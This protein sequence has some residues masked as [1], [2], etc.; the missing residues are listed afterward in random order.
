[1]NNAGR[2]IGKTA[3][4]F[5]EEDISTIMAANFQYAFHLS[6]LSHPL[7]KASG[8]GNIVFVSSVA[9]FKATSQLSSVYAASK[10]TF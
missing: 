9:S 4:E 7:L 1:M 8:N 5:T 2:V 3:L 10:G 6:Q